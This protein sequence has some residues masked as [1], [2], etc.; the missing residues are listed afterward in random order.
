MIIDVVGKIYRAGKTKT[1]KN[2]YNLL[3][4]RADG[5]FDN[6]TLFSDKE[7]KAGQ[8]IRVKANVYVQMG[9]EG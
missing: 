6:F 9:N 8:E 5:Q 1:G 2:F 3:I 7:Y 4:A